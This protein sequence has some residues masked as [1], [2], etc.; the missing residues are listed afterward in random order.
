MRDLS[1]IGSSFVLPDMVSQRLVHEYNM[2]KDSAQS[3]CQ[4][5]LPV[6]AQFVAGPFHFLGLDFFN[7][8][9]HSVALSDRARS[10]YNGIGPV[11]AARIARIAP[12]YGMG[13]VWNTKLRTAW[14]EALVEQR[15][16]PPQRHRHGS[17]EKSYLA[18]LGRLFGGERVTTS[19]T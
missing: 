14:R 12:G 2:D 17:A 8:Q 5:T 15:K 13:G 6:A 4:L 1:V 7:K 3:L 11:V 19:L 10:L 18:E 9:Q 16:T